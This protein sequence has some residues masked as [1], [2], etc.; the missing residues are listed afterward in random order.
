MIQQTSPGWW[1]FYKAVTDPGNSVPNLNHLV[2]VNR[3]GWSQTSPPSAMQDVH[4][5]RGPTGASGAT[6]LKYVMW[7]DP[8]T[9]AVHNTAFFSELAAIVVNGCLEVED[10]IVQ[11]VAWHYTHTHT[12]IVFECT[13]KARAHTHTLT[14]THSQRVHD[15]DTHTHTHT[16][17]VIVVMCAMKVHKLHRM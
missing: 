4:Q 11:C 12:V 16:H 17:T 3:P 6:K 8:G 5:L 1:G 7:A 15:E 14:H 13:I 9:E 10:P 2:V